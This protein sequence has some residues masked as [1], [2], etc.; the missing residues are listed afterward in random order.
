[1]EAYRGKFCGWEESAGME[2][3]EGSEGGAYNPE[4]QIEGVGPTLLDDVYSE[5]GGDHRRL[6]MYRFHQATSG[7][8]HIPRQKLTRCD[9][10]PSN[11]PI[12]SIA[13]YDVL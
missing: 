11:F 13:K 6:L 7:M 3:E 1:M 9:D 10:M 2:A 12:D 4:K 5:V 8:I